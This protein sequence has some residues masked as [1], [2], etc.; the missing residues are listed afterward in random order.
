MDEGGSILTLGD[1]LLNTSQFLKQSFLG[2]LSYIQLT[3]EHCGGWDADPPRPSIVTNPHTAVFASK[4]NE[5]MNDLTK[6]RKLKHL[7]GIR[8]QTLVL[9]IPHIVIFN[10]MQMFPC[11]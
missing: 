5:L 1:F 8:T 7:D 11:T 4:T 2:L 3:L 9:L 6:G 10:Q